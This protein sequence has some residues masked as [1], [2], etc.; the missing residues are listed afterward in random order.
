MSNDFED[1]LEDNIQLLS[2]K[3]KVEEYQFYWGKKINKLEKKIEIR[4]NRKK[5]NCKLFIAVGFVYSLC[6]ETQG[7]MRTRPIGGGKCCR[8]W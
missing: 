4:D 2:V 1:V 7:E 8:I 3:R 6:D 5:Y